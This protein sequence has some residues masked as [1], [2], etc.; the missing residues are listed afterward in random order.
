[1]GAFAEEKYGRKP[2]LFAGGVMSNRLMRERLSARFDALFAEGAF[3]ADN[4]AGIALLA[5]EKF[6]SES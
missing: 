4:A 2:V 1:M 3:S 6:F 5:R